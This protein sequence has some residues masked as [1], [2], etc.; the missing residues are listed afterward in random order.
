[1]LY[2]KYHRNYIRQFKEGTE[3]IYKTCDVTIKDTV[4]LEP[5]YDKVYGSRSI[6]VT[7]YKYSWPLV[8]YN[9]KLDYKT[10]IVE[11]VV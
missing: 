5:Y 4:K 3:V 9:G 8:H 11:D 7:G 2:K 10:E 6:Y 1:M